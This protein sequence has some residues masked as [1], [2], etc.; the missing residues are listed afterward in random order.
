MGTSNTGNTFKKW[1]KYDPET[2]QFPK[3]ETSID[4]VFKNVDPTVAEQIDEFKNLL[5]KLIISWLVLM[6]FVL[7]STEKLR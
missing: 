1:A 3:V 5:R 2:K 4:F 7:S 6:N